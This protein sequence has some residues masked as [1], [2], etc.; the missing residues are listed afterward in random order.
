MH[1]TL[2]I[3]SVQGDENSEARG[4][5]DQARIFLAQMLAHVFALEPSLNIAAGFIGAALV[6]T[7]MQTCC[8]PSLLFG[9]RHFDARCIV[10]LSARFVFL[11]TL[12]QL[13]LRFTGQWQSRQLVFFVRQDG[14]D[15]AMNQQVRIAANRAG[16]VRVGFVGQAK[17][18]TVDGRVNGLLHRAQQHGVNLLRVRSFLGGL[19][20]V[21]KLTRLRRITD[22]VGQAQGLQVIAQ[23][24]FF[25]GRGALVHTEQTRMLA[26]LNKVGTAH[27][28]CQHGLFNETVRFSANTRHNFVNAAVVIANDL[29]FSG[30]KIDSAAN[31]TRCQQGTVHI[32]Q[33]EQVVHACFALDGLGAACVG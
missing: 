25:L 7:A 17:V 4:R 6:G 30:L 3:Q 8:F 28:G 21:L 5:C 29:C 12:G 23:Q 27:V 16:E 13:G 24:I 11:Q 19:C 32:V 2:N 22:R 18:T 14:L 20:N 33:I 15:H 9:G 31:S 26:V 1:Q 10:H